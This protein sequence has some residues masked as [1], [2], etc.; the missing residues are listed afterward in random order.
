MQKSPTQ[1]TIEVSVS[2]TEEELR[3]IFALAAL[4]SATMMA[5]LALIMRLGDIIEEI[6]PPREAADALNKMKLVLSMDDNAMDM[7]WW[8]NAQP[9]VVS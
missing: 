3:A 8:A 9:T 6:V 2:L 7:A 1:E 5:D 4:G